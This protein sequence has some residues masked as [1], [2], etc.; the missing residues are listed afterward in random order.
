MASRLKDWKSMS[1]TADPTERS[2]LQFAVQPDPNLKKS[3]K[4][5]EDFKL[6]DERPE[7]AAEPIINRINASIFCVT[8]LNQLKIYRLCEAEEREV[9]GLAQSKTFQ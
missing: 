2:F 1:L 6:S 7:G 8:L 5:S 9:L 4:P 3:I